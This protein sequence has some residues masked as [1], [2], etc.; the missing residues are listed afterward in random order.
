M[1]LPPPPS[2][3]VQNDWYFTCAYACTY[4]SWERCTMSDG[5]WERHMSY[6]TVLS[7]A[8]SRPPCNSL[9]HTAIHCNTLQYTAKHCN[10]LQHTATHCNTLQH[11]V[12]HCNYCNTMQHTATHCNSMQHTA[13]HCNTLQ[14]PQDWPHGGSTTKPRRNEMR[15]QIITFPPH[16]GPISN[17][18]CEWVRLT[19]TK[20]GRS[21]LCKLIHCSSV[22]GINHLRVYVTNRNTRSVYCESSVLQKITTRN[23]VI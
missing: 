8:T 20:S 12:T 18:L 6:T 2:S 21:Y 3:R 23:Y 11:T 15:I 7:L 5:L 9:Q 17:L 16:F 4:A 13:T 10:A 19:T 1:Y 14:H 22:S